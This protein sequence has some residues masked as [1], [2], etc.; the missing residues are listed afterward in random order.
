LGT[1]GEREQLYLT[2]KKH[3]QKDG[4]LSIPFKV[5]SHGTNMERI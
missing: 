4:S 2:V 5:L 3:A 1:E